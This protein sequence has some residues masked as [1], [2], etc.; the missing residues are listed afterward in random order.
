M[1][2]VGCGFGG[3]GGDG[4]GCLL[5]FSCD[6]ICSSCPIVTG[7]SGKIMAS[8]DPDSISG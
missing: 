2:S 1:V 3:G 8:F 6:M 4:G 5:V 7:W